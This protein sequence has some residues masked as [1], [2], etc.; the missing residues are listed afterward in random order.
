MGAATQGWGASVESGLGPIVDLG[1]YGTV[2]VPVRPYWSNDL[3][4]QPGGGVRLTMHELAGLPELAYGLKMPKVY[5]VSERDIVAEKD[6]PTVIWIPPDNDWRRAKQLW[7]EQLGAGIASGVKIV[8]MT[9]EPAPGAA[10]IVIPNPV[11]P[12][13][14]SLCSPEYEKQWA[15]SGSRSGEPQYI[16]P[17]HVGVKGHVSVCGLLNMTG[18]PASPR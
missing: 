5:K 15:N 16:S 8:R 9:V 6:Y 14:V 12:V 10:T 2:I 17:Y 18:K 7:Y 1:G 4:R 13:I 3:L 11:P